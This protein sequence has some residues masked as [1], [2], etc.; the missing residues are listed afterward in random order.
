MNN[1]GMTILSMKKKDALGSTIN[2]MSLK[3]LLGNCDDLINEE[4]MLQYY[5]FLGGIQKQ[6]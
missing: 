5:V 2:E 6:T 4:P 3:Y 1:G